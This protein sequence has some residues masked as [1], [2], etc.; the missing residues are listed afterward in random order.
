MTRE[1]HDIGH[2]VGNRKAGVM[3]PGAVAGGLKEHV[4]VERFVDALVVHRKQAGVQVLVTEDRH[5]TVRDDRGKAW[6]ADAGYIWHINA[7][8]GSGVEIF[9]DSKASAEWRGHCEWLGKAIATALGVEWRGVKVKNGFAALRSVKNDCLIELFFVD[10]ARNRARWKENFGKAVSA[11]DRVIGKRNNPKVRPVPA[12]PRAPRPPATGLAPRPVWYGKPVKL[13]FW[14]RTH[15]DSRVASWQAKMRKRGWKVAVDGK[16]GAESKRI[17]L[18]FQSE[19]RLEGWRDRNGKR[20]VVD[21]ILGAQAWEA[22]FTAD[23]T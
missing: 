23:V 8:G 6:G 22:T 18:A 21:G 17:L 2:G 20:M 11:A 10:N 1:W 15:K 7:G 19:K 9:V 12:P 5:V 16:F 4:E 14:T 13:S 3:D